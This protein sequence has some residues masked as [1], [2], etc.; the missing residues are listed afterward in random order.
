MGLFQ[1]GKCST[2]LNYTNVHTGPGQSGQARPAPLAQIGIKRQN[3]ACMEPIAGNS[4][5]SSR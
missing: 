4:A 3:A 1:E 5:R 2:D